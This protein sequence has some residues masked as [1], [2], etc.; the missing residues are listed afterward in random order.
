MGD[1]AGIGPEIGL[2]AAHAANA[3][4]LLL[5]DPEFLR[6]RQRDL[7]LD[8]ALHEVSSAEEARSVKD[9]ALPVLGVTEV[10]NEAGHA[11][12]PRPDDGRVALECL[13]CG[14]DLAERGVVDALVTGPLNKDLVA[15]HQPGFRGH[16]EYLADRAG[17]R[18][19]IMLFAGPRPHVAL[20]TTH[21]PTATAIAMITRDRVSR[22]LCR[23]DA[24]WRRAFG[25]PPR[26]GVAALNPHAGEAGLLGTDES[27]VL[28][29]AIGDA[30]ATGVLASGPF[31]ADSIFRRAEID[32]VLAL[33]HDQGTIMAKRAG[34]PSVNVTLGLPYP[35]TSP[36]HGPA[37]DLASGGADWAPMRAAL[38]MAFELAGSD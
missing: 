8:V 21:L 28:G 32:V 12:R 3:K 23:L 27:D 19:P 17:I 14:A 2:R 13:R 20:L 15:L 38:R 30:R 36:D 11:G 25:A 34:A 22:S 35:R 7:G 1:P 16:T 9:G 5:G 33:Y 37:Y 29:P 4:V 31:P 6:R 24:A 10:G 26:I 18:R